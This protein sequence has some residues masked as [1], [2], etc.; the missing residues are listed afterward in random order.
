MRVRIHSV[1][2]VTEVN[3]PG[4]RFGIWFQGC[5]GKCPECYN[6][7]AQD[8]AGGYEASVAE[9]VQQII[10]TPGI[11]GVSISG[12]EPLEQSAALIE[13]MTKIKGETA[14]SILVFTAF[15]MEQL[16]AYPLVLQL[17]DHI[18]LNHQQKI[19]DGGCSQQPSVCASNQ[20]PQE[21]E[22]HILENGDIKITGF[23]TEDE[24]EIIKCV[25]S[26]QIE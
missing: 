5:S 20:L 2:P 8:F 1:I 24:K 25:V 12:G 13:L 14:L 17:A 26:Q 4:K 11:E 9:L 19:S 6:P 23:P 10:N 16:Q 22:L 15:T 7:E 3:G 18:V 21:I